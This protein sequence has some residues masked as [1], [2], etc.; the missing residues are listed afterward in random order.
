MSSEH[1]ILNRI[2]MLFLIGATLVSGVLAVQQL[3]QVLGGGTV[4]H[5]Q[6]HPQHLVYHTMI[7]GAFAVVSAISGAALYRL[8]RTR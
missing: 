6:Q 7:T 5:L 3:L 8:I 1:K 4:Q 2:L